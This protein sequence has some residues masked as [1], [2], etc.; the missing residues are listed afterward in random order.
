MIDDELV[1]STNEVTPSQV[2][3]VED[4]VNKRQIGAYHLLE[5]IGAGGMGTVWLAEQRT[6][7]Y[8]RVAMKIIKAELTGKDVIARFEAE[9]QA[10]AMMDHPNIAKVLDAGQTEDGS[11]YLVMEYVAGKPIT[12]FCDVNNTSI[13]DRL[14]LFVLVCRA[15]QHAH[16]KGII[17]RDLKPSNILVVETEGFPIPRVIDFG[18]A[19][20]VDHTRRLTDKTLYTEIGKVVGTLQYMSPEQAA[21]NS[22]DIDT[23]SDIYSLGVILYELLTGSTPL[24]RKS[25]HQQAVLKILELIQSSDPPRPSARLRDS[26]DSITGISQHRKVEVKR[27]QSMLEGELDWVVMR[28]LEKDR[29]RRYETAASLADDIHR[30]LISE[31]VVARPPSRAYWLSKFV[32]RN[33]TAFLVGWLLL[34]LSVASF[35]GVLFGW[36]QS[37]RSAQ[38]AEENERQAKEFVTKLG[39]N[40]EKAYSALEHLSKNL[41]T[42]LK[43]FHS[44]AFESDAADAKSKDLLLKS[45][46]S[47][48][49]LYSMLG[50]HFRLQRAKPEEWGKWFELAEKEYASL[51]RDELLKTGG[52]AS[53]TTTLDNLAYFQ[54]MVHQPQAALQSSKKILQLLEQLRQKS[55]PEQL[56]ELLFKE[57]TFCLNAGNYGDAYEM[58]SHG[59]ETFLVMKKREPWQET[60]L[61]KLLVNRAGAPDSKG[62]LEHAEL[63]CLHAIEILE[64]YDDIDSLMTAY[65]T[66]SEILAKKQSLDKR[67]IYV[68]KANQLMENRRK[69]NPD[70]QPGGSEL[71]LLFNEALH[72]HQQ[73]NLDEALAGYSQLIPYLEKSLATNPR[74]RFEQ[75]YVQ[76]FWNRAEVF[77]SMKKM[78]EA[79][80]DYREAISAVIGSG[81]PR[82]MVNLNYLFVSL[83]ELEAI[84]NPIKSAKQSDLLSA[85]Y[86]GKE[87]TLTKLAGIQALAAKANTEKTERDRWID[88]AFETLFAIRDQNLM[89][90]E[91]RTA[92]QDGE[93]FQLLRADAR[94]ESLFIN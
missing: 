29:K 1:P 93:D 63:D 59:I 58:F 64:R 24:E 75:V 8:R 94:W 46:E 69:E 74:L 60:L 3:D 23:R 89:T 19:K 28:A 26:G 12:E 68:E 73:G 54:A 51:E 21:L 71:T 11:P 49:N 67:E 43:G 25:I 41:G 34:F 18:L 79:I 22:S 62:S 90:D 48:A 91:V 50:F 65:N 52:I 61:G 33:R 76:S 55:P 80:P 84:V 4:W 82:L 13:E 6:P 42:N 85:D 40:Q 77:V 27:L 39:E 86:N 66:M 56:D 72:Q 20:S 35:V 14:Q 10:L 70:W 17:H 53:Y 88:K 31:P 2:E 47:L 5:E 44:Q 78:K 57:A 37:I 9:R 38:L 36:R 15:V 32:Q 92:V 83:A 7:V 30:F 45:R 87:V 16:Q 81:D